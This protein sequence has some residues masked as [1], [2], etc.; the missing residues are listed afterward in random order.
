MC[1]IYLIGSLKRNTQLGDFT[2][3]KVEKIMSKWLTGSRDRDGKRAQ[4]A[5][6]EQEKR[7]KLGKEDKNICLMMNRIAN[8][9]ARLIA[10]RINDL[11][12]AQAEDVKEDKKMSLMMTIMRPVVKEL[13]KLRPAQAKDIK[14]DK[15]VNL[16][17]IV[18]PVA[19]VERPK[20]STNKVC[21]RR[22]RDESDNEHDYVASSRTVNRVKAR[23]D[24][25]RKRE[26]LGL[27]SNEHDVESD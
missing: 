24:N 8:R 22:R 16:M 27:A 12:S 20:T 15:T 13:N 10:E 5:K 14:E 7:T 3:H 6:A 18:S 25:V 26:E 4:R 17:T 19:R 9:I 11:R 23:G 21:K 2:Q 1:C